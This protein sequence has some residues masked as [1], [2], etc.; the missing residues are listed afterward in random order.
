MAVQAE[1]WRRLGQMEIKLGFSCLAGLMRGVA[2]V[3]ARV[4]C[5]VPAALRWNIC[6]LRVA[7]KAEIV[8]L[9]PGGRLEQLVFILGRVRI[10]ALHAVAHRRRVNSP[11]DISSFLVGVAGNAE[12]A[13]GSGDEFQTGDIPIHSDLVTARTAHGNRRMD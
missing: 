1:G 2:S 4:E 5:G 13:G 6:S 8:F 3:A 7:R 12:S 10:V 9:V 11:F